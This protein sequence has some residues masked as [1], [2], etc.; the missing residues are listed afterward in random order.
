MWIVRFPV[1]VGCLSACWIASVAAAEPQIAELQKAV[2]TSAERFEKA[3]AARDAKA[4]AAQFTAEAE[5]VDA[6]GTVFHGR[7]AIEAEF[8]ANFAVAPAGTLQTEVMSI[9]PIAPGIAVEEGVSIFKPKETGPSARTRYTAIH[10]RQQ[11]GSW[12]LA[13]VRE[14]QS[15]EA[16][17]HDHLLE[18][19]WLLG[20]WREEIGSSVVA[21]KW[22]WSADG[23]YLLAH[24]TVREDEQREFS[25]THRV[26][27]DAERKQFRSWLF[28]SAGGYAEGW[29]TVAGDGSSWAVQLSGPNA[30]G[31]RRSGLMTYTPDGKDAIVIS[32]TER[33]VAGASLSA[34]SH[35]IVRQPPPLPKQP[36]PR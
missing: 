21:T 4:I 25:G 24:F 32:Q 19:S 13:S 2:S 8:T 22:E 26:G 27:W 28:D 35:R 29:W 7:E 31:H 10:A 1:L 20:D 18:L 14:L 17:P 36:L 33:V 9:R 34:V 30:A 5:Y 12:L 3:F 15:G 11:D 16:A 6:T 23:N